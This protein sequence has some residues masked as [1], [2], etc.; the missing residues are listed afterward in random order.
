MVSVAFGDH[1]IEGVECRLFEHE[2]NQLTFSVCN[3]TLD[4]DV[5][6]ALPIEHRQCVRIRFNVYPI[7][8]VLVE[9]QCVGESSRM[10]R[11]HVNVEACLLPCEKPLQNQIF[12]FLRIGLARVP[13]PMS[14]HE[15]TKSPHNSGRQI[16][17]VNPF[18]IR[19]GTTRMDFN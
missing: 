16:A 12:S 11:A 8:S 3:A 14:H 2:V 9:A 13:P 5:T 1:R 18:H 17:Q 15:L 4:V 10:M 19:D 6:F 7:P